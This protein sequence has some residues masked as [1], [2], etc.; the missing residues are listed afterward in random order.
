M[1]IEIAEPPSVEDLN[2]LHQ[3]VVGLCGKAEKVLPEAL[4]AAWRAGHLLIAFKKE[5]RAKAGHGAWGPWLAKHFSGSQRTAQRYMGLAKNVTDVTEFKGMSLRQTYMALGLSVESK[6]PRDPV[7]VPTLPG[8][9]RVAN[10]F[11]AILPNTRELGRIPPT[12]R[13]RLKNDLRPVWERLRLLF[14]AR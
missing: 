10:R 8:H 9:I 2:Q 12:E 1:T 6:G 3:T 4:N 7:K 11:I 5:V 13:E 14:E